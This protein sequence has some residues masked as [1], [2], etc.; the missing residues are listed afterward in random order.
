MHTIT[1]RPRISFAPK[2]LGY[3]FNSSRFHNQ[4]L[5][6]IQGTK[7]SSIS[8]SAVADLY[9]EYPSIDEQQAIA[10]VLSGMDA[11]IDAIEAKRKKYEA[12]KQGMMQQL[13][14]GKIRLIETKENQSNTITNPE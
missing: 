9:V 6:L 14:T 13:L 1:L 8:R 7:V 11:D 3:Y 10:A 5:P 2:F 12:I 4:I